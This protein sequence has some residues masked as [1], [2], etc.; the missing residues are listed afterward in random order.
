[1]RYVDGYVLV[2]PTKKLKA[3]KKMADEGGEIWMKH[4][5]LQYMECVGDDL[6]SVDQWGGL[7]FPRMIEA[8]KGETVIFSYIVYKSKKHRDAVNKKVHKEMEKIY[9]EEKEK[10]MP[11]DMK[12]MAYG[13]FEAIVDL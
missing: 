9:D 3:Y 10:D 2:V 12:R 6:K 11:F 5:A 7:G 4:G 8:K 13:G 1:M